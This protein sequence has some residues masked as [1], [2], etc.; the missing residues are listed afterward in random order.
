MSEPRNYQ[1]PFGWLPDSIGQYGPEARARQMELAAQA[2][3]EGLAPQ[4]AWRRDL[5]NA[6]KGPDL[7]LWDGQRARIARWS[8]TMLRRAGGVAEWGWMEVPFSGA[9]VHPTAWAAINPPA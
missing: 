9:Q 2:G 8:D 6:P 4:I 1:Y 3:L 7:L 5:E